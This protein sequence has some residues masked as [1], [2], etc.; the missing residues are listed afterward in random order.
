MSKRRINAF[1]ITIIEVSD[2]KG[3]IMQAERA[4]DIEKH[5]NK[6]NINVQNTEMDVREL[7]FLFDDMEYQKY[8]YINHEPYLKIYR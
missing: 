8:K 1:R 5:L 6:L 3:L 4:E 2:D 7:S